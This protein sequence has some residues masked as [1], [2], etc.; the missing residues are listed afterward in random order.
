MS[1]WTIVVTGLAL[2]GASASV[3]AKD[4]FE[5]LTQAILTCQAIAADDARLRCYDQA[6]P[7]LKSA[8]DQGSVVLSEPKGPAAREGVVKA[9]GQS[10]ENSYWIEMESG[11]RWRLLPT[12]ARRGPPQPGSTIKVRKPFTGS[13][14]WI[15]GSDWKES[16]A[17]FV[18]RGS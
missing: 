17:E 6:M 1:R 18:G 14:Y 13:G 9:A 10:G 16:R 15:S 12:T 3:P 5:P 8:I 11:D 7:A 2:L 4:K